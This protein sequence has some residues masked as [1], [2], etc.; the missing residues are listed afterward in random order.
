MKLTAGDR[1]GD[2]ELESEL[3]RGSFATVYRVRDTVLGRT[4]VL[5]VLPRE[6]GGGDAALFEARLL[7][8]LRSAHITAL[9]GVHEI[10][11]A[12]WGLEMEHVDGGTLESSLDAE[13]RLACKTALEVLRGVLG[14]LET[15][16]EQGILHRD[17][18]PANVLLGKDG[19]VKLT[20]FGLG[21]RSWE[22][23]KPTDGVTSGTPLY[24]APE[25]LQGRVASVRTDLWSV[26]VL[27]YH[28]L[29]GRPP[30]EGRN[31]AEVFAAV[32]TARPAR[33]GPPVPR[34]LERWIRG[35]LAREPAGRPACARDA[36]AALEAACGRTAVRASPPEGAD[37]RETVSLVASEL[38]RATA[39][40][41]EGRAEEARRL[42]R[43][44]QAAAARLG[45]GWMLATS[46]AARLARRARTPRAG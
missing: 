38:L 24:M 35:C 41:R 3:G 21:G 31:L 42:A 4:A 40:E 12:H 37:E 5:K 26:G 15:A 28:M 45:D 13:G 44:A 9:Y 1:I 23:A 18:K 30:F 34:R 11:D 27:A 25:L 43:A 19:A 14:A 16:H 17:V 29:S 6:P 2:L 22:E 10:D 33:L 36:L 7:R 20:D 8:G 46:E 32:R 39:A